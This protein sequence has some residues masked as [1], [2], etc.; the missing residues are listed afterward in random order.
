MGGM[1]SSMWIWT[2]IGVL[3]VAAARRGDRKDPAKAV[4][5]RWAVFALI[6]FALNFVWEMAQGKWFASMQGLPFWHATLLCLRATIGDLAITAAAFA[7]AAAVVKDVIW[8]VGQRVVSATTLFIAF[9]L[10]VSITYEL[11]AVSAGKWHYGERM[12][13]LFGLGVLPL[14]QWLMLPVAEVM[15]FRVIWRR[16][17]GASV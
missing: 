3:V 11:L 9:G 4:I 15:L 16:R 6:V 10:A 12:P 17:W 14:L 8:P 13:T 7:V 2:I 5:R 1:M